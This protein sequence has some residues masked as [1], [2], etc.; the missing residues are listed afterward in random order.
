ME[1]TISDILR[2][3]EAKKEFTDN[4]L[5]LAESEIDREPSLLSRDR[6]KAAT[7]IEG[8]VDRSDIYKSVENAINQLAASHVDSILSSIREI[9]RQ[10]VGEE[11]AAKEEQAGNTTEEEIEEH[12]RMFRAERERLH[13]EALREQER[14]EQEEAKAREEELRKRREMERRREE[15]ERARER[16][17]EERRRAERERLREEQRALDEQR[18]RE[19]YDRRRRDDSW[20][21]DRDRDRDRYRDRTRDYDLPRGY[22]RYEGTSSRYRDRRA[23]SPT[24]KEL[25]PPPPAPVDDKTLEEAALQLLLHKLRDSLAIYLESILLGTWGALRRWAAA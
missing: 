22:D 15:E 23:R 10:E 4:L 14:K 8:A 20:D 6:G 7:L 25:T 5:K 12:M 2:D 24:P 11:V 9:R 16:E 18:E 13:Q 1:T 3:Q 17:R 21:R 19:R